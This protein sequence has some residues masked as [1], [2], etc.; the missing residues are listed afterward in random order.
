MG[1]PTVTG[2]SSDPRRG[3]GFRVGHVT[4]DATPTMSDTAANVP[5]TPGA[6]L[7][8]YTH[9]NHPELPQCPCADPGNYMMGEQGVGDLGIVLRC[10]CGNTM[11]G[12]FDTEQERT[13]FLAA[14]KGDRGG[15]DA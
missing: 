11:G 2:G 3:G 6:V 4:A 7:F 14:A 5:R 9:V 1:E 8:G 12:S 10:W 13:D 15:D